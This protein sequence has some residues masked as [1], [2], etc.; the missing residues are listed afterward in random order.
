MR[1]EII[2]DLLNLKKAIVIDYMQEQIY[3][4]NIKKRTPG[5]KVLVYKK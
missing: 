1:K 3:R 4:Y 2:K 5:A